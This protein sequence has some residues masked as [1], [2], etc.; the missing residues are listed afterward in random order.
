MLKGQM[1]HK[2]KINNEMGLWNLFLLTWFV[3]SEE[4]QHTHTRHTNK[5]N[6]RNQKSKFLGRVL[7]L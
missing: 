2:A 6:S 5:D 4:P 7:K 3:A 1:I